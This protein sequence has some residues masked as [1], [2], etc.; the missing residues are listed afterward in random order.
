M[1][2]LSRHS[3]SSPN[4]A[5]PANSSKKRK[6]SELGE[7]EP[8]LNGTSEQTPVKT[9]ASR[10]RPKALKE[11]EPE[12]IVKCPA[13]KTVKATANVFR[14]RED[15]GVPELGIEYEV[16]YGSRWQA[17]RSYKNVKCKP[18]E[19]QNVFFYLLVALNRSILMLSSTGAD[20]HYRPDHLCQ[21]E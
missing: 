12:F 4:S 21:P 18:T 7:E 11:E 13:P 15:P 1:A 17:M 20:I 10:G 3:L 9:K 6:A 2:R 14:A 5:T 16:T 8:E 19:C